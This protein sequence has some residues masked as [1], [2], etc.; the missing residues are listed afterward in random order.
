MRQ[1]E[2]FTKTRREAPKDEVARNAELLIRAG[3][4]DKELAGAYSY[5][6]LG[7]RVVENV[8]TIM[9][10]EM[11]AIGGQELLLTSLQ[12]RKLWEK[13]DRWS[14][15]KVDI[16]FKS[17]D[18]DYGFAWSHEEPIINM[19]IHH[20]NSYKDL[21]V[22]AYQ[23]QK[24]FRNERRAKSGL[25]RGREF[26]M[27]DLY[28]FSENQGGLD[29][30]YEECISA[31]KNIFNKVGIGDITYLTYASGH[32]FTEFSHEFQTLSEVGEDTIYLSE[33]DK[34]AINKEIYKDEF[35]SEIGLK[36]DDLVEKKS[37]EVG[38]IFKF[39]TQKSET[40]GLKYKDEN[41]KEKPVFVGSYGIG[42]G[43]L[44]ATVVE[45]LSDDKGLV[46]PD[47]IS[48]FQ[49]YLIELDDGLGEKLYKKL[50]GEGIEVFYD[51]REL[52]PGEKFNDAD[53]IGIPWRFVVSSKTKDMV[54]CKKRTEERMET[55]AY[56]KA[57][58][59]LL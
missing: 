11:N 55:I 18:G 57:I 14:E 48:P 16:W 10:E 36:K 2:L 32:P 5:L 38:N 45:T 3:F 31:Y 23:F 7:L 37:I 15:D 56:D 24:K 40:L 50:E 26:F 12:N 34:V 20:I 52:A 49:V 30:F 41:G 28:S 39:G 42:I 29:N 22:Y 13:T 35:V 19:M 21:P 43:R 46:W 54:E 8:K 59:K 44:I 25:L 27:K 17:K 47:T 53:L 33:K 6:P 51:D 1:S 58:R 9:R 4:V